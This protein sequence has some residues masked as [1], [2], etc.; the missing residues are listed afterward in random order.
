MVRAQAVFVLPTA[1]PVTSTTLNYAPVAVGIVLIGT[2]ATW[3][4][5][6]IGARKWYRGA[7]A[8][9]GAMEKLRE[10]DE[11]VRSGKA[12]KPVTV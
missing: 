11:S 12:Y 9:E 5:P 4:M 2:L 10:I 6:V 1:Y 8:A 3:F 7:A